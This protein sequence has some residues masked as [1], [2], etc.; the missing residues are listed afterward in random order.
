MDI[1]VSGKIF[2]RHYMA[3]VCPPKKQSC[4]CPCFAVICDSY[5]FSDD[6]HDIKLEY[7][8]KTVK[9]ILLV[10]YVGGTTAYVHT[11]MCEATPYSKIGLL[12]NLTGLFVQ[13]EALMLNFSM[14]V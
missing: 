13:V 2:V 6:S 12:L 10:S 11:R 5:C 14:L 8:I 9:D 1:L 4:G 3:E 7:L